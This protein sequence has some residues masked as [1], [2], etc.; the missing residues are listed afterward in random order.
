MS[1]AI[2]INTRPSRVRRLKSWARCTYLRWRIRE[3][4]SDIA[5]WEQE[6]ECLPFTAG[7]DEDQKDDYGLVLCISIR[8]AREFI[9]TLQRRINTLE[10][11]Q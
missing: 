5:H 9:W 11:H 1:A 7:L 4:R 2:V 10:N 3:A 8:E 6:L